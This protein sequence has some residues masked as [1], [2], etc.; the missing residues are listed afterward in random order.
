MT[1]VEAMRNRILRAMGG[2]PQGDARKAY[3]AGRTHRSDPRFTP[4]AIGPNLLADS[5]LDMVWRRSRYLADNHPIISGAVTTICTN[6]AGSDI[7]PIPRTRWKDV[8]EQIKRLFWKA[9]EAVDLSRET[10][11]HESQQMFV[12][13]LCMTGECIVHRPIAPLFMRHAPGPV[14][15][16]LP[17]EQ[18][19]IG[20]NY[21]INKQISVRQ[22]IER[23]MLGR[24][25]AFRV[26]D[27]IPSDGETMPLGMYTGVSFETRRLGRD[28]A[29]HAILGLRRKTGQLRGVPLIMTAIMASREMAGFTEANIQLA[30]AVACVGLYFT[31]ASTL[32]T[33]GEPN[34]NILDGNGD[35]V[36]EMYPGMVGMLPD[37]VEPKLLSPNVPGPQFTSVVEHLIRNMAAGCNLSYGA[38]SH[39][40]SK[41]TFSAA[42][43]EQLDDR[44]LYRPFQFAVWHWHT[45]PWYQ[46]LIDWWIASGE[47]SLPADAQIAYE[48]DRHELYACSVMF[49]GWEW[50]NPQQEAQAT[51]MAIQAGV[52]SVPEACAQKGRDW[53]DVLEEQ[54]EYEAEFQ[55][56][57]GRAYNPQGSSGAVATDPADP[58]EDGLEPATE[59]LP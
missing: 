32:N 49:P 41:T 13:E 12:R 43:A 33:P 34:P 36:R 1:L 8:N 23:D 6:T 17:A 7:Y 52:M 22:G 26:F 37:K 19:P 53:Q 59:G 51:M 42:R 40:R 39:D 27:T 28:Q 58:V 3:E 45:R 31:N 21:R 11:V 48:R 9:V 35:P 30:R 50:V 56:R 47:L 20:L 25:L 15:S 4:M 10:P 29:D 44:K 14:I 54:Q 5:T 2:V 38:L 55:L 24:R 18:M 16:L 57:M 46:D